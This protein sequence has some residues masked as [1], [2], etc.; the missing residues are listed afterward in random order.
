M[1]SD[2]ELGGRAFKSLSGI[3]GVTV[4]VMG[5]ANLKIEIL[6]ISVLH[7]VIVM[8][9]LEAGMLVGCEL[10]KRLPNVIYDCQ[11]MKLMRLEDRITELVYTVKRCGKFEELT[12]EDVL[13]TDI[14]L[15]EGIMT[16]FSNVSENQTGNWHEKYKKRKTKKRVVKEYPGGK[17]YKSQVDQKGGKIKSSRT[18]E[19]LTVE[20]V[21]ESESYVGEG[22][23]TNVGNNSERRQKT[24]DVNNKKIK[25]RL[26]T[27]ERRSKI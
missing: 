7:Q 17:T 11:R 3:S 5:V 10:L 13:D 15:G 19:E 1:D 8:R 24:Q 20:E 18:F 9:H 4:P 21:L 12:I 26:L 25:G 14:D 22:I 27:G 23:K 16:T 2:A 6:G